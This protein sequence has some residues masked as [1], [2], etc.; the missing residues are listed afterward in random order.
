[1]IRGPKA[2]RWERS[3][4]NTVLQGGDTAPLL[5]YVTECIRL[6]VNKLILHKITS[7]CDQ[8]EFS[9]KTLT[10]FCKHRRRESGTIT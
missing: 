10:T 4:S 6:L 7:F 8:R 3:P 1:M 5:F 9:Q 2:W